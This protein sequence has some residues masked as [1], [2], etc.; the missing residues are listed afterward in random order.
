VS[1]DYGQFFYDEHI[2]IDQIIFVAANLDQPCEAFEDFLRDNDP[3]LIAKL[4]GVPVR[5]IR[6]AQK[7]DEFAIVIEEVSRS[8]KHGF[9]VHAATPIPVAFH[10]NGHTSYGFGWCELAW[11]YAETLDIELTKN[12]LAWKG[13]VHTRARER[14]TAKAKAVRKET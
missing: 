14:I 13:E 12:L 10:D 2:R 8:S 7:D 4:L 11:F 5:A 3:K 6:D 9:L 1:F